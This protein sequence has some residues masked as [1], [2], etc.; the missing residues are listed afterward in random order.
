MIELK[1]IQFSYGK[2]S[3][4]KEFS[5]Q[6]SAGKFYGVFGANGSGKSTLLRLITGELKPESGTVFPC[7][8]TAE[9]RARMIGFMEQQCPEL[10]PLTVRDVVELGRYPWR[11]S[12]KSFSIEPILE[13]LNL[14]PL[15]NRIYSTL[16][17]GE[18]QRVM[19]ARVLVQDTPVLLLDEPFSSLDIGNQHHFYGILKELANG[20]KCVIMVTHDVFVSREYLDE[21][22][23]LNDG[24][25]YQSGAPG[26]IFSERL[27][28]EIYRVN[29]G[30]RFQR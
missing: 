21:T 18:K 12:G 2:T 24:S 10:I 27:F 28:H 7:Y 6:F 17:G 8:K 25:L 26:E 22:L 19:L 16:S 30:M 11:K 15:Q 4:L 20:G 13:R 14:I 1:N 23:F 29:E 5:Y 3:V 9:E